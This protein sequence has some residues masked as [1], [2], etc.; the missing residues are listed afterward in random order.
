[1]Q[2]P[3]F[4]HV[5]NRFSNDFLTTPPSLYAHSHN[6]RTNALMTSQGNARFNG[7]TNCNELALWL[8]LRFVRPTPSDRVPLARM[9]Y[10]T[11][12]TMLVSCRPILPSCLA[13]C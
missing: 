11:D 2:W 3:H 8:I 1:M 4:W 7:P 9:P 10:L 12:M 6:N 5:G 13:D